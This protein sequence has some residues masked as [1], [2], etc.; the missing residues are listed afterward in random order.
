MVDISLI[1]Q[2]LACDRV[3]LATNKQKKGMENVLQ[4]IGWLAG[5]SKTKED[6]NLLQNYFN[7]NYGKTANF[8]RIQVV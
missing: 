4:L 7:Y 1:C 5:A 6:Q 2:S 3:K 8:K